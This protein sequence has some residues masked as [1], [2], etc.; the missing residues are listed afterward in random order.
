VRLQRDR[1]SV[2]V[3]RHPQGSAPSTWKLNTSLLLRLRPSPL[4]S[5]D[6]TISPRLNM[7]LTG[8]DNWCGTRCGLCLL[9]LPSARVDVPV[10]ESGEEETG[11]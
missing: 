9:F 7:G 6:N 2:R 5:N 8:S 11:D 1:P 10:R 4:P 3:Q